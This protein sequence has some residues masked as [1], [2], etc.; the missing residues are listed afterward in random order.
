MLIVMRFFFYNGMFVCPY[1]KGGGVGP[2][3]H[4]FLRHLSFLNVK[5]R[6]LSIFK[7]V[8]TIGWLEGLITNVQYRY[9]SSLDS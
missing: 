4:S 5:K 3:A 2:L 9:K 8:I 1:F 6:Y 7:E